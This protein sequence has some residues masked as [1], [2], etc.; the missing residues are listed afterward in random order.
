MPIPTRPLDAHERR[1]LAFFRTAFAGLPLGIK[2]FLGRSARAFAMTTWGLQKSVEDVDRDIVPSA[3]SSDE[4]L[5]E[6]ASISGL[7]NGQ[8]GYG[9][10]LPTQ[11]D[12]GT[13]TL[14]GDKGTQYDIGLLA[15]DE[16]GQ[17]E[18]E[19]KNTV[20]IAGSPPGSGSS[21]A[22]EAT[23]KAITAGQA[24]NLKAGTVCTW[25][26]PPTGADPTFTLLSELEGG[27]ELEDKPSVFSR[28]QQRMRTPPRGGSEQDY[29]DWAQAAGARFVFV[30]PRRSGTGSV[31]V[32]ILIAGSGQARLPGSE[33]ITAVQAYI[34]SKRP[35]GEEFVNVIAPDA[36][37]AAGLTVRV[38]V[39]P[40]P[41]YE[42]DW[43]DTSG[44]FTVFAYAAGPPA[45]ITLNTTAPAS[46]TDAIDAFIANTG[47]APRLQ[48]LSTPSHPTG[49]GAINLPVRAV[50][51]D[52]I[53]TPGKTILTL[54]TLPTGWIAPTA[55]D[56]VYAYGPVVGPIAEAI[57]ELVDALG[58]SRLSGYAD[59]KHTWR[60]ALALSE[61]IRVAGEATDGENQL[62]TE[63][64]PGGATIN[65]TAADKEASDFMIVGPELL[66]C[67]KIAVTG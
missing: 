10:L 16:S 49:S 62:I 39:A 8:N 60:D 3:N 61:L 47:D 27:A 20:I 4:A 44:T 63:V 37:N 26:N 64:L 9:R 6:W 42:F 25:E 36:P 21:S 33:L 11:A 58:P 31:D 30:Y 50:A 56:Q 55:N 51:Y 46:L 13:A 28:F 18:I 57:L 67:L 29:I 34:D 52:N 65:G 54:E 1:V 17:V 38:R 32:V 2:R 45:K 22:G 40:S 14:T 48:V 43:T 5:S 12:G 66:Y 35:A 24:G 23:F 59:Q 15:T 53:T 7:P 41:G 19:L